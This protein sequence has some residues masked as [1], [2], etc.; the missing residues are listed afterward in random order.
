LTAK[1][2]LELNLL[3]Y[4]N[5]KPQVVTSRRVMRNRSAGTKTDL[6]A[7]HSLDAVAGGYI[8]EFVGFRDPIQRYIGA[9]WRTRKRQIVPG[10]EHRLVPVFDDK[11]P[12]KGK[13]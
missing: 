7:S 5:I 13:R 3:N 1:S 9:L 4:P 8:H 2:D 11:P 12:K 6:D 10:R